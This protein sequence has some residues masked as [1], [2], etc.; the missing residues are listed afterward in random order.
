M[1]KSSADLPFEL[2]YATLYVSAVY[3]M[4]D[5]PF[6]ADRFLMYLAVGMMNSLIS[7]SVGLTIG[8]ALKLKVKKELI[9]RVVELKRFFL[10]TAVFM[11]PIVCNFCIILAG[12]L[13]SE[14]TAPVYLNW[15][16]YTVYF[17]YAFQASIVTLFGF[18]R[19]KL[20]CST[21]YCMFKSPSAV[22]QQFEVDGSVYWINMLVLAGYFVAFRIVAYFLLLRRIRYAKH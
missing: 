3:F 21:A 15:I 11:G 9:F 17:K 12:F 8:I 13:L 10:Q 7:Q 18:D 14:S 16:F 5:Q 1:A 4:T 22:L 2:I 19:E 6:E 20:D